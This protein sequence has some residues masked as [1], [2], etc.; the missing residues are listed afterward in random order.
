MKKRRFRPPL[1]CQ[2]AGMWLGMG[3]SAPALGAGVGEARS[4]IMGASVGMTTGGR[5][6]GARPPAGTGAAASGATIAPATALEPEPDAGCDTGEPGTPK[7]TCGPLRKPPAPD[8]GRVLPLPQSQWH[9]Q[10]RSSSTQLSRVDAASNVNK[11]VCIDHA[12]RLTGAGEPPIFADIAIQRHSW[13]IADPLLATGTTDYR[14]W[15][16]F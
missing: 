10:L 12:D 1:G 14:C 13:L 16:G 5:T 9:V 11:S 6:I 15:S 3:M 4:P 2:S 8:H 7:R